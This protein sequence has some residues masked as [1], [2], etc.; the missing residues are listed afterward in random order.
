M[1]YG[2]RGYPGKSEEHGY[3]GA[4]KHGATPR[5]AGHGLNRKD[6]LPKGK[7]AQNIERGVEES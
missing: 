6:I 3:K 1:F 4:V 5:L 7:G 2:K